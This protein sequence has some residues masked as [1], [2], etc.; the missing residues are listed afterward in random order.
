[1]W[2]GLQA[3]PGVTVHGP[4]PER[5]RTPTVSF[6]VAGR[7]PVDVARHLATRAVFASH[8]NFYAATVTE[9]L[10]LP[11]GL[12]RAGAACYTTLD[13]VDRL[14]AGVAEVAGVAPPARLLV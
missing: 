11:E 8:G 10:G 7:R 2:D 13:E 6:T 4:T 9:R 3:V 12:V 1:M 5:P 14:V